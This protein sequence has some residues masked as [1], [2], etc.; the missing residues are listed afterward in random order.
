MKAI[1]FGIFL[2]FTFLGAYYFIF[3][4]EGISNNNFGAAIY[5]LSEYQKDLENFKPFLKNIASIKNLTDFKEYVKK[6]SQIVSYEFNNRSNEYNGFIFDFDSTGKLINVESKIRFGSSG[7][8]DYKE[9]FAP[10]ISYIF[11]HTEYENINWGIIHIL[12]LFY[13]IIIAITIVISFLLF[14]LKK[15]IKYISNIIIY[16]I[17]AL[18]INC[19]H[20]MLSNKYFIDKDTPFMM[21]S[22][23]SQKTFLKAMG[24]TTHYNAMIFDA[25][26][27]SLI[28]LFI[29][30][31]IFLNKNKATV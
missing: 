26:I 17:F 25:N 8:D 23:P 12:W 27:I 16:L 22:I 10:I 7:L 18:I 2:L 6:D 24:L 20:L 11:E 4:R 15:N 5:T 30:F 9:N 3:Y 31:T 28:L 14:R 21:M 19:F 13:L 1:I 29:F